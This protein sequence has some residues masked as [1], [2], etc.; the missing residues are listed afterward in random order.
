MIATAERV[1][2]KAE[3][4]RTHFRDLL[5]ERDRALLDLRL[6]EVRL[7]PLAAQMAAVREDCERPPARLQNRYCRADTAC[8]DAYRQLVTIAKAL[9]GVA[10]E[11]RGTLLHPEHFLAPLGAW[12]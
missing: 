8:R 5:A 10:A 9:R 4:L 3:S 7:A 11:L 6:A 12:E 2:S 1:Q